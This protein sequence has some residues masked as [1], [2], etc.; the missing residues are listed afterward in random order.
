MSLSD[1]F[2][3]KKSVGFKDHTDYHSHILPGVDD[4]VKSFDDSLAILQEYEQWG[5]TDVFL[6]PHIMADYPNTTEALKACFLELSSMYQGNVRLH[7]S[8]ENML[9]DL[10]LERLKKNDL[11]PFGKTSDCLLVETSCFNPPLGFHDTLMDIRMKGYIPV[12]AHP[13]RYNYMKR[14]DYHKL[15]EMGVE[16]Q[17]NLL[18]PTGTY[19][20]HVMKK[21]VWLEKQGY[22]SYWG[23]D[24]HRPHMLE[25]LRKSS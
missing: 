18:S 9:D 7:L 19:G 15:H 2:K 12:L 5:L 8:A 11:L 16:F 20:S 24:I 17:M 25:L 10:F 14:D 13:E 21:A 6:T 22:Y 3:R 23:S 1:L 4:G